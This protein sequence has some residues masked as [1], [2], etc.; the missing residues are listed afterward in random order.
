VILSPDER[1]ELLEGR[2]VVGADVPEPWIVDVARGRVEVL[3]DPDA[4]VGEYRTRRTYDREHVLTTSVLPAL[5]LPARDLL[6]G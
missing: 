3:S 4:P 2:I 6:G 1:I 5:A